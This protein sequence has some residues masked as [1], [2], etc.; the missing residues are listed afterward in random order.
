MNVL[1]F[2]I[3]ILTFLSLISC[4]GTKDA[5]G[6]KARSDNSDEFL[7]EKKNPLSMPPDFNE[8]PMPKDSINKVD[9]EN[10][11]KLKNKLKVSN[12]KNNKSNLDKQNSNTLEENILEKINN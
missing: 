2:L 6:G 9:N 5:L 11:Q 7:V 12:T 1:R 3:I 8:L 10:N 4:Q